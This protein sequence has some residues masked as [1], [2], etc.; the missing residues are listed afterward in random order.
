MEYKH[1]EGAKAVVLQGKVYMGR[2]TTTVQSYDRVLQ[3][4]ETLPEAP[5]KNYCMVDYQS[6][7]VL[8]GGFNGVSLVS[9][10]YV[11]HEEER[12]WSNND[13][14]P[15]QIPR[16]KATAA[17]FGKYIVILGGSIH[18][19]WGFGSSSLKSVEVYD[20]VTRQW[21]NG[22]DLPRA[23]C[24]MQSACADEFLYLLNPDGWTI[25][26][27]SL[28][29]L[30]DTA[31]RSGSREGI[32]QTVGR[33]VP[34][35]CCS[36]T[37]Y[38]QTLI[39]LAGAGSDGHVYAYNPKNKKWEKIEC[40]VSLPAIKNACCL[41]VGQKELILCGGD[42]DMMNKTAR[43]GYYLCVEE[44]PQDNPDG[45]NEDELVPSDGELV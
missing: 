27:C 12:R 21:Y 45:N 6:Q 7:L 3:I 19:M 33:S 4:W 44:P 29:L 18:R 43:T 2:A 26:Y 36:L 5:V 41:Q 31:V 13:I 28:N 10:L 30:V 40:S 16:E 42:I 11:Y 39:T 1:V 9:D 24:L 8:A 32:W 37:V 23:G 35:T 14:P 25:R 17:S 34:Y 38:N 15:M 22:P 20:G